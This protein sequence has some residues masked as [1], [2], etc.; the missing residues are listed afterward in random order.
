MT[1]RISEE[2]TM[3]PII[4]DMKDMSD[5]REV[6]ESKPSKIIPIFIYVICTLI[7]VAFVWMYFGK[8]DIVVKSTG[9]IRPDESVGTVSNVYGGNVQEV[10]V[11]D[12]DC[13]EEGDVL[14]TINHDE[15]LVEKEY[16]EK[17][18]EE[19]KEYLRLTNK[20]K[21]CLQKSANLFSEKNELEY[22][23]KYETYKICLESLKKKFTNQEENISYQ[24]EYASEQKEYYQNEANSISLLISSIQEGNN[25]FSKTSNREYY[26]KYC[27]YQSDYKALEKKYDDQETE[28]KTSISK[29]QGKNSLEY[30]SEVEKQLKLLQ[31]S[32]KKNKNY[33]DEDN[34]YSMQY[35]TYKQ[36]KE[37]LEQAFE[38]AKKTYEANLELKDIA[39]TAWEVE[40]SRLAKE[41]AYD[42][43]T[44]YKTATLLN[45]SNQLTEVT[46]K[47][48]D[49][50]LSDDNSLTKE[51]LLQDNKQSKQDALNNYKLQYIVDLE[52]KLKTAKETVS[53]LVDKE[54]GL[55]LNEEQDYIYKDSDNSSNKYG[56]V[57]SFQNEELTATIQAITTYKAKISE[58]ETNLEKLKQS[59]DSCI[60]RAKWSGKV[61]MSID[62]VKGNTLASGE[63]VLT[64]LPDGKSQYKVRIYVSNS[65][66][67]KIKEGMPV[68]FNI[69]A[70][71]NTEYGYV[72][73]II[74]KVSSD[75]KV[76]S[77]S[78]MAYYLVESTLDT[79]GIYEKE[80]T[81]IE[82]KAG[83]SCEAKII[84]EQ[85]RIITYVLE[86]LELLVKN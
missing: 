27:M 61:N 47:L 78:G 64:V 71:P 56:E 49:L 81:K 68:K 20:Y 70:Y 16:Y 82:I 31:K 62:L 86:K 19:N 34:A 24:K 37:E 54:K 7:I 22:Y 35:V 25:K 60:V 6:Y 45:I 39:V 50:K 30:Y 48:K 69:L 79:S 32:I 4:I 43:I 41:N 11:R 76:D 77:Q 84:T 83:M 28:I 8:I 74:T 80:G 65:D 40:E 42:A 18:L 67:G 26:N 75:I 14:Y 15:L 63:E 85:K 38:T 13:V 12:G 10:T 29:E 52:S 3:K 5:S 17:Q 59:I 55:D 36:K 44:N 57:A 23:T 66:I 1:K 72:T 2:G 9:M 53:S 21:E 33:I 46:Q 51:D 58:L 73:G